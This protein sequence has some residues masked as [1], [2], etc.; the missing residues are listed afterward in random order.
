MIKLSLPF[1]FFPVL[2]FS[3]SA[4][5][6]IP[7]KKIVV[8][9]NNALVR[10]NDSI[11]VL[12]P[13]EVNG[14]YG[15]VGQNGKTIITP[16]YSNVGFFDEDCRLKNSPNPKVQKF[17]SHQ[18]ASVR[19][20]KTNYRIDQRGNKVYTFKDSDLGKCSSDYRKQIFH[21]Y[22]KNGFYGIIEDSRFQNPEDY[23]HYTIY[24]QYQYIHILEGDDLH[25][26]MI[27]ASQNDRFGVIDI[28]NKIIIPFEYAD[29]KR[30][31]SWKTARLFEVS[32]D[33]MHFFFVD[34]DNK[35]Y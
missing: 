22:L 1:L 28:H 25:H 3:Q 33:G 24:P 21:A 6:S 13:H 23:R 31:L 29:I 2:F 27:I 26:P 7:V 10:I 16:E 14:K 35:A 5:K 11:P 12:I 20:D 32:R 19:K 30:N 34:T 15:F 18:Y 4:K 8:K 9:N 17:G